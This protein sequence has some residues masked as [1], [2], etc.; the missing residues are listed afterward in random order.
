KFKLFDEVQPRKV[1]LASQQG[2]CDDFATLAADVLHEKGYTTRLIA[3]FMEKQVHVVC[4]VKEVG[5][6]LDYNNR[7]KPSPLVPTNGRLADIAGKVA[8]SFHQPWMSVLE[9]TYKNGVKHTVMADFPTQ[10]G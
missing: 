9:Y 5:A 1:F 10:Q 3:V 8:R 4:Y 6:Y 7:K 2:D